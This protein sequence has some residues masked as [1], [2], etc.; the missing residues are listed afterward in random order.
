MQKAFYLK[1]L[2]LRGKKEAQSERTRQDSITK[3]TEKP[4]RKLQKK[5]DAIHGHMDRLNFH[6]FINSGCDLLRSQL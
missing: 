5:V 3:S 6:S 4:Q 1:R 2:C